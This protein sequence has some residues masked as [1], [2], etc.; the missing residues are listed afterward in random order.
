[1]TS[2]C[3]NLLAEE[4]QAQ[5][6]RA[7]DPIKLVAAIGLCLLTAA[8]AWGGILSGLLMQ[9]RTEVQSLESKSRGVNDNGAAEG[10]FQ[11]L[12]AQAE[13]IASVNRSR[14]LMAPELALLEDIIP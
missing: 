4:Q 5:E 3:L 8:V 14:I 6:A 9:K 11:G 10:E 12:N 2:I 1:M 7:R 13:Q